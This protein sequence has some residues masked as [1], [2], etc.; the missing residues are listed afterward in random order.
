MQ[1]TQCPKEPATFKDYQ[2]LEPKGDFEQSKVNLT[3][4]DFE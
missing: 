2:D 4:V 3:R 1:Y